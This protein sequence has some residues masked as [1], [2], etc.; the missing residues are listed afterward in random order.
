MSH[1]K[2]ILPKHSSLSKALEA[3][4]SNMKRKSSYKSAMSVVDEYF[5][6]IGD[7]RKKKQPKPTVKDLREWA[8]ENRLISL[9]L[10]IPFMI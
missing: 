10:R 4:D 9:E 1:S 3:I 2:T 6:D 7:S 8:E 5:L